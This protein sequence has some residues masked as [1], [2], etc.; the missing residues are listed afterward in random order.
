[1]VMVIVLQIFLFAKPS[2]SLKNSQLKSKLFLLSI[3]RELLEMI[4]IYLYIRYI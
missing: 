1:M 2:P 4:L 3:R